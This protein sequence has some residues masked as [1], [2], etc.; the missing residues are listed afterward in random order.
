MTE[1]VDVRYN[2]N[3][4]EKQEARSDIC[5]FCAEQ[6]YADSEYEVRACEYL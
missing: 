1:S 3:S 6:R 5:L 4:A 2:R